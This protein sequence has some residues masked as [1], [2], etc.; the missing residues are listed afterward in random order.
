M[1]SLL[2]KRSEKANELG[3]L[4]GNCLVKVSSSRSVDSSWNVSF[5]PPKK[6]CSQLKI[7]SMKGTPNQ[8]TSA[9]S[10]TVHLLFFALPKSLVASSSKPICIKSTPKQ[11]IPSVYQPNMCS[12]R[13]GRNQTSGLADCTVYKRSH[14]C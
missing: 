9:V 11:I 5:R 6:P 1:A 12:R 13:S 14:E 3:A 7:L 8:T 10:N 2:Y 4:R